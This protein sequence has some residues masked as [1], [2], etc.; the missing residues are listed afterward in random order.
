MFRLSAKAS[1]GIWLVAAFAVFLGT[2]V[3]QVVTITR[4]C[5][6]L[7]AAVVSRVTPG[8]TASEVQRELETIRVTFYGSDE[9]TAPAAT[10]EI[11]VQLDYEFITR[12]FTSRRCRYAFISL[13]AHDRVL[14]VQ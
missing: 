14:R 10:R 2:F 1:I 13:D 3:Y 4:G 5:D 7:R 12:R 6:R 8:M 9:A 11:A